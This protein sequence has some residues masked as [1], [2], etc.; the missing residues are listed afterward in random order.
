[1]Y[2]SDTCSELVLPNV[3]QMNAVLPGSNISETK[4]TEYLK[5]QTRELWSRNLVHFTGK[6]YINVECCNESLPP[7]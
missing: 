3:F 5:K 7:I 6:I 2:I 4:P 1:M